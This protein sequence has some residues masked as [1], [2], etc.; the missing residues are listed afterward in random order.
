[1]KIAWKLCN[2]RSI[3]DNKIYSRGIRKLFPNFEVSKILELKIKPE[4]NKMKI[5][6][7]HAEYQ[8]KIQNY[9]HKY[10]HIRIFIAKVNIL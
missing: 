4:V 9:I 10:A 7:K 8:L 3:K 2:E 5:K 6:N 1:M